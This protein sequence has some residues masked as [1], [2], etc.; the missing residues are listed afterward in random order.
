[1]V[2]IG[3]SSA[4]G[5]RPY[6]EEDGEEEQ[7]M[8]TDQ[9]ASMKM[10]APAISMSNNLNNIDSSVNVQGD[11]DIGEYIIKCGYRPSE[12]CDFTIRSNCLTYIK[13][14]NMV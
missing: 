8:T 4:P 12:G 11:G 2:K 1:L 5:K 9:E 6:A 10:K 3:D 14:G 7:Q 13:L